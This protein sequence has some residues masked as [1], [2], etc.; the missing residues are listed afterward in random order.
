MFQ[1][2]DF[3][4]DRSQHVLEIVMNQLKTVTRKQNKMNRGA[5]RMFPV[6][7]YLQESSVVS[8]AELVH[9]TVHRRPTG[10]VRNDIQPKNSATPATT[11]A[12]QR[13]EE[14]AELGQQVSAA[15]LRHRYPNTDHVVRVGSS[16]SSHHIF[17]GRYWFGFHADRGPRA[18]GEGRRVQYQQYREHRYGRN[19]LDVDAHRFRRR[20]STHF[21]RDVNRNVHRFALLKG[22]V[23]FG[24]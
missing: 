13:L 8:F 2:F 14:L 9:D 15:D 21:S 23:E 12:H 5:R 10:V 4:I 19:V 3:T 7:F 16:R 24:P 6:L 11:P 20:I 18:G 1:R 22:F 17:R